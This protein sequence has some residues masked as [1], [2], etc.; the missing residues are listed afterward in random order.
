MGS[1][2]T[3]APV[4][5]AGASPPADAGAVEDAADAGDADAAVVSNLA[6]QSGPFL[7]GSCP[8]DASASLDGNAPVSDLG[9]A[10]I[11]LGHRAA[12]LCCP[13][14]RDPGGTCEADASFVAYNALC[15]RD[16]DCTKGTN[17][18]CG[19]FSYVNLEPQP[20][21]DADPTP[22]VLTVG[23]ES[24]CSYDEC[25]SDDDCPGHVPCDCR[26]SLF[27]TNVCRKGSNCNVDSDCGQ[28]G[29]CTPYKDAYY[30]HRPGDVCFN[31][32]DC[33]QGQWGAGCVFGTGAGQW[34]CVSNP[35][36]IR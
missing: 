6:P 14:T 17:G 11:P 8:F 13:V 25:F 2:E 24:E 15:A 26:A 30:C 36:G 19:V 29:Y 3:G 35:P 12:A 28:G 34:Q 27:L 18:R 22:G 16:S 9:D 5:E 31:D 7:D 1:A 21:S 33:P 32:D 10:D 4:V 23:C 20:G